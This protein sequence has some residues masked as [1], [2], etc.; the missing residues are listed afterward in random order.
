MVGMKLP[1]VAGQRWQRIEWQIN[2]L[3]MQFSVLDRQIQRL[4]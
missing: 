1:E 3:F 2:V 4:D